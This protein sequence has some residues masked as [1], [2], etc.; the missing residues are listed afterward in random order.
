MSDPV[1]YKRALQL[2]LP[3]SIASLITPVLGL[4]DA[5]V[6]GY[7]PR[8]LDVGAVGLAAAIFSLLF[9]TF[10]F[11]R[12]S[13]A[14][15]TAQAIGASDEARARRT[16]AQS[17]GLGAL[18]GLAMLV[19]QKPMGDLCFWFMTRGATV[20]PDAIEAARDYYA[21]RIW[22]APFVLA[23][24]GML[25]WLTA[26]GRTDLLMVIAILTTLLNAGLD[27]LLVL[28]YDLGAAGIAAGTLVAEIFSALISA[29]A[30][31]LL[32]HRSGGVHAHWQGMDYFS[33]RALKRLLS[34]NL[35]IFIRTFILSVSYVYFIQRSGVF[36]DLTLSANQVLMQFFLVTGL[37]LDGPAIA[38]ETLVGQ[39]LGRKSATQ[40][41]QEFRD[42]VIKTS[43]IGAAG[44]CLLCGGY[45]ILDD[46]LLNLVAP[47]G[48]IN[49]VARE[50]F[51]W[52]SLS[53]L[54]VAAA[55]QFDGIYIG[56]TRS[57]ALRN[58]MIVS[59][60]FYVL[61]IGLLIPAWGNHG[62]WIAFLTYM[63][64]R[65]ATLALAWPGFALVL[66]RGLPEAT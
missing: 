48:A 54:A 19:L 30:I 47:A 21:I 43:V 1:T 56:A 63:L 31:L 15:L 20:V 12:M 29:A 8:P 59:A 27:A 62:L 65:A 52:I 38:A 23:T 6:L 16:L 14:G 39:A 41:R 60:L 9:W 45:F 33:A 2:A 18:I 22:G 53:P 57:R 26:R 49:S 11:L 13:T 34:V 66:E 44:A 35:D 28:H 37:A 10:G 42:A 64:A 51:I 24:S 7:S 32:L 58:S 50:Y 61:L 4:T 25:G 40:R 3:A 5:A 55:F 17:V 36:G 46:L